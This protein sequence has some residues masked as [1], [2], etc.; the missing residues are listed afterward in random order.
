M[1]GTLSCILGLQVD[2]SRVLY[3]LQTPLHIHYTSLEQSYEEISEVILF[4]LKGLKPPR[5]KYQFELPGCLTLRLTIS[6]HHL[7][8]QFFISN[9]LNL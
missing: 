8:V 3:S 1:H 7:A 4:K 2:N 6:Q 5:E 9:A